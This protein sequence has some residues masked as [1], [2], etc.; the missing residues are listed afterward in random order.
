MSDKFA[1]SSVNIY[2][3]K[4]VELLPR[5]IEDGRSPDEGDVHS[6]AVKNV[7]IHCFT[8]SLEARSRPSGGWAS[9]YCF[10]VKYALNERCAGRTAGAD[11]RISF[12][13]ASR[14]RIDVDDDRL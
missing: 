11:V 8:S 6:L 12:D 1:R 4:M 13:N 3:S 2:A 10:S 5:Q 7:P 14:D 9:F